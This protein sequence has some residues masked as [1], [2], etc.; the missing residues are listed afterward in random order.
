MADIILKNRDNIPTTYS[1]DGKIKIPKSGGGYTEFSQGGGGGFTPR[2]LVPYESVTNM[3]GGYTLTQEN[4]Y[5]E[6]VGQTASN[7]TFMANVKC[8]LTFSTCG[9]VNA[10]YRILNAGESFSLEGSFIV[11]HIRIYVL[12]EYD[13][14]KT[15]IGIFYGIPL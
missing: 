6:L 13:A 3:G 12:E 4:L 10:G 14:D 2:L 15:T 1:V 9:S 7:W 8:Y 5:F 11:A